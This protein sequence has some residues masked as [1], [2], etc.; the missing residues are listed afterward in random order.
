MFSGPW[1]FCRLVNRTGDA[2]VLARLGGAATG[3]EP[4]LRIVKFM[5]FFL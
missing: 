3:A 2:R 1:V 5:R 4:H